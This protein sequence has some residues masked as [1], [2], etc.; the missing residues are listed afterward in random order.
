MVYV[1][2]LELDFYLWVLNVFD[3]DNALDVYETSGLPDNV[4]WLSSAE[5]QQFIQDY[6]DPD[7]A[8]GLN[9]QEKYEL[10]Q[11]DPSNFDIPRMIRF[12]VRIG[13]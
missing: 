5:G 9:G 13:F 7:D 3:K 12:G 6:S 8:T 4:G 2:R 1:G 10:R 11:N